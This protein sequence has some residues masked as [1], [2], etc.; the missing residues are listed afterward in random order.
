MRMNVFAGVALTAIATLWIAPAMAAPVVASGDIDAGYSYSTADHGGGSLS[1]W[2]IGGGAVLP[3]GSN[4]AVQGNVGYSNLSGS[5]VSEDN[6]YGIVSAFYASGMGRIG[7]SG[8]YTQLSASHITGDVTSYG[9]FGD[10]YAGNAVTLSARG[11]GISGTGHGGGGSAS[12]NGAYYLGGQV[13]GYVTPD[14][15]LNGTVDYVKIPVSGVS[16]QD[17]AYRVGGEY[18][19][20]H[21]MPLAVSASYSYSSANVLGFTA[22]ANTFSVG[23]K[24]YFGGSGSLEDHQRSG[25]EGWGASSPAQNLNL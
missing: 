1:D 20:S 12:F 13:V 6:T 25:S 4:W 14:F 19:F 2:T 10:W 15:A 22:N 5:G 21:S 8:G 24:Y 18:M 9:G 7:A 23:L 16:I 17:T 3:L 11:G